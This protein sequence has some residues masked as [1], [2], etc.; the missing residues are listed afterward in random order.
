M[1]PIFSQY[2]NTN[3]DMVTKINCSWILLVFFVN[4]SVA[5][6]NIDIIE[7]FN[8]DEEIALLDK[9]ITRLYLKSDKSFQRNNIQIYH[10][11]HLNPISDIKLDSIFSKGADSLVLL[12]FIVRSSFFNKNKGFINTTAIICDSK[13]NL[14]AVSD[15]YKIANAS[16]FAEKYR[17]HINEELI[18]LKD[19]SRFIFNVYS[20]P[21]NILFCFSKD[22]SFV[23]KSTNTGLVKYSIVE[24]KE[25]Y[26]RNSSNRPK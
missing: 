3:S 1:L 2:L 22:S 9:R 23:I 4:V 17:F 18:F 14:L 8:L 12:D 11:Y 20:L 26:Y 15:G 24:F 7:H 5:Q 13:D 6:N 25:S 19:K 16:T 21:I 10:I